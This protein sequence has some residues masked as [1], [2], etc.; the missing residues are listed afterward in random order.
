MRIIIII[1]IIISIYLQN[2][3]PVNITYKPIR[4]TNIIH[5]FWTGG[6]DS[7]FRICQALIDEKKTVQPIYVSCSKVDGY[8]ILGNRINRQ[9]IKFEKKAMNKIRQLINQRYP[10]TKK[11]FLKT[12]YV[13][14]I[15]EDPEYKQAMKNLFYAKFGILAPVLNQHFGY[16][17]RPYN[18]YTAL[19]QYTKNYN[20]PVEVAVEKC[21]TGLDMHTRKFRIGIGNNCKLIK[22]KPNDLKI[23][24]KFRF[25]VVHLTKKEM[26]TISNKNKY[27]N[28]LKLT[29]SCWFPNNG[30]PCGECDM[31]TH[32]VI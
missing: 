25:P 3:V 31:C 32:R 22:D 4:K 16:F 28:I 8:F 18:Q 10:Y 2:G 5:I 13:D 11:S 6:F 24:D 29:W 21:N 20:Y 17:S 26:L 12:K 23:F 15:I 19:A 14:T 30:K 1:L 7:T 27:D 9:N